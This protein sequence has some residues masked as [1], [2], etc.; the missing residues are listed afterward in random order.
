MINWLITAID[1]FVEKQREKQKKSFNKETSKVE[2][3]KGLVKAINQADVEMIE[4]ILENTS[5]KVDNSIRDQIKTGH[6]LTSYIFYVETPL[7]FA[8]EILSSKRTDMVPVIECLLNKGANPNTPNDHKDLCMNQVAKSGNIEAVRLLSKHGGKARWDNHHVINATTNLLARFLDRSSTVT[9]EKI[10]GTQLILASLNEEELPPRVMVMFSENLL[11]HQLPMSLMDDLIA[12]SAGKFSVEKDT[13]LLHPTINGMLMYIRDYIDKRTPDDTSSTA[14]LDE[15]VVTEQRL[16][17]A[18]PS[19]IEELK[20]YLDNFKGFIPVFEKQGINLTILLDHYRSK[21]TSEAILEVLQYMQGLGIDLNFKNSSKSEM[22]S[23]LIDEALSYTYGADNKEIFQMRRKFVEGLLALKVKPILSARVA[24]HADERDMDFLL[25]HEGG[26]IT[27]IGKDDKPYLVSK[28]DYLRAQ[29]I[30]YGRSCQ[31]TWTYK[32]EPHLSPWSS[33]VAR[34]YALVDGIPST[35]DG[36]KPKRILAGDI[37]FRD[38]FPQIMRMVEKANLAYDALT[39]V[40][41]QEVAYEEALLRTQKINPRQIAL[42][43]GSPALEREVL[44]LTKE[45]I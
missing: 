9:K 12:K 15:G 16:V 37:A 42:P 2:A 32:G 22:N 39:L 11:E 1:W 26:K 30:E 6:P 38:Q 7:Q 23:G 10:E 35:L 31:F 40:P 24:S 44:M 43:Q 8:C 18:K 21:E 45:T 14:R 29:S 20:P 33:Q 27:V 36:Q 13:D 5:F 3:A 17:V 28:K 25:A 19:I 4:H 34:E 41:G